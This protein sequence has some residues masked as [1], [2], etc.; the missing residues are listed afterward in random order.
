MDAKECQ[1][2]GTVKYHNYAFRY[3]SHI[4]VRQLSLRDSSQTLAPVELVGSLEISLAV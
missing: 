1:E 4:D 3:F 2:T